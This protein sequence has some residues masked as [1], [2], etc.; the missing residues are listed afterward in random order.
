M[1]D[2]ENDDGYFVTSPLADLLDRPDNVCLNVA[3]N[4]N[5]GLFS[6]NSFLNAAT[7][8]ICGMCRRECRFLC[9]RL[10]LYGR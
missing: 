9:H 3:P 1:H 6:R 2:T 10:E 8:A 5:T 7:K 4:S